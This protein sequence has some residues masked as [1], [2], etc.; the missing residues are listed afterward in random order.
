MKSTTPL[1]ILL[2]VLLFSCKKD[3]DTNQWAVPKVKTETYES[4]LTRSF[5]Y[6]REGRITKNDDGEYRSE[7]TYEP[8]KVT[9]NTTELAS[10][11][12]QSLTMDLNPEGYVT[13]LGNATYTY[14]AEGYIK[15]RVSTSTNGPATFYIHYYN[16]TTKLLDSVVRLKGSNWEQTTVYAFYTD[17][18]ETLGNEN[19]G[20]VF[21]GKSM[22]HPVKKVTYWAPK[23]GNPDREIIITEEYQYQY[24]EAGRIVKETSI[25]TT[26]GQAAPSVS[27]IYTYY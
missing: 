13:K 10:G 2:F 22:P 14:T 25:T 19:F 21:Y 3:A 9:A 27:I 8:S 11:G 23:Q 26:Y 18:N 20:Q 15:N 16:T 24:N 17:K 4:G 5:Y 12:F 7:Y 6:D 1:T